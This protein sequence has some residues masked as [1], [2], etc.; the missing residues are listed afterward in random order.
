MG[1][2]LG[3][4]ISI[5]CCLK[6]NTFLPIKF[7]IIIRHNPIILFNPN[8]PPFLN[9]HSDYKKFSGMSTSYQV[10]PLGSVTVLTSYP[11]NSLPNILGKSEYFLRIV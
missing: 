8:T 4:P 11:L 6:S 2:I 1:V 9:C 5:V 3:T 7:Y 10:F